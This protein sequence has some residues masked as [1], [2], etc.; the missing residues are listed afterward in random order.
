[1]REEDHS[2]TVVYVVQLMI[3]ARLDDILAKLMRREVPSVTRYA[4]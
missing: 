4:Q 1:M 2:W 3:E